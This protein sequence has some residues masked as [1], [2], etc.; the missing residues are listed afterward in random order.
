M[1]VFGTAAFMAMTLVN[2]TLFVVLMVAV[3]RR[4]KAHH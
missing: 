2:A 1:Q 4:T 3:L